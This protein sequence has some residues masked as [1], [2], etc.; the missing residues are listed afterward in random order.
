MKK[1]VILVTISLILIMLGCTGCNCF[2]SITRQSNLPTEEDQKETILVYKEYAHRINDKD[3]MLE[4]Y[5][6]ERFDG[7][8]ECDIRTL[9]DNFVL[10]HGGLLDEIKTVEDA[11]NN[12][13][14]ILEDAL[15][16]IPDNKKLI[17]DIKYMN[18]LS[19]LKIMIENYKDKIIILSTSSYYPYTCKSNMPDIECLRY[20]SDQEAINKITYVDDKHNLDGFV[21]IFTIATEN[22][23]KDLRK[24]GYKV[25]I[26]GRVEEH[27]IGYIDGQIS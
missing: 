15:S 14:T 25:Y 2:N 7:G 1:I 3:K 21:L 5:D 6:N 27:H 23:V 26:Y 8:I 24:K 20:I 10:S 19:T 4:Y 22:I 17:I 18:N 9:D 11:K 12:G 16:I 13:Y